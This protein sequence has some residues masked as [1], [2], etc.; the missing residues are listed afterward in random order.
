MAIKES[1]QYVITSHINILYGCIICIVLLI[2]L[3]IIDSNELKQRNLLHKQLKIATIKF[4]T[5]QHN[6][7]HNI[8]TCV[9]N[10]AISCIIGVIFGIMISVCYQKINK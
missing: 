5:L 9:F 2:F 4:K 8:N 7:E 10:C 6:Y 1:R 3:I